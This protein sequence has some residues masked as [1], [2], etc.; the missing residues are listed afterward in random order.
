MEHVLDNKT[1][2]PSYTRLLAAV[3]ILTVIYLAAL[4]QGL[5]QRGTAAVVAGA[6]AAVVTGAGA[7][8]VTGAATVV[9]GAGV[10]TTVVGATEASGTV[11]VSA[12]IV[13]D[14][15]VVSLVIDPSSESR[16]NRK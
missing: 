11:V 9:A 7:A 14:D 1:A 5:P 3:G 6:G 13:V 10:M 16:R 4:V 8:V 15:G 12:R 2:P